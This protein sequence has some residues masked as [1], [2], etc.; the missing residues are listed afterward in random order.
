MGNKWGRAALWVA[1]GVIAGIAAGFIGNAS[2]GNSLFSPSTWILAA[3]L[4]VAF[5]AAEL[6]R[7]SRRQR[8]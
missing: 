5:G 7:A 2:T 4:G 6:W 8:T 1:L 3:V